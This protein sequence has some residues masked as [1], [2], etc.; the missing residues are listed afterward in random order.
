M[1]SHFRRSPTRPRPFMS[2]VGAVSN[3]RP[4]DL[5]YLSPY[6]TSHVKRF[7]G[8]PGIHPDGFATAGSNLTAWNKDDTGHGP[9]RFRAFM[10]P[11][12]RKSYFSVNLT[13]RPVREK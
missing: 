9:L 1:L 12:K 5:A 2:C 11:S 7:W 3:S 13:L 10:I 6:P 8:I 4:G